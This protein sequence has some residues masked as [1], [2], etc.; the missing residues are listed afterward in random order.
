MVLAYL[1]PVDVL[2][3]RCVQRRWY[4]LSRPAVRFNADYAAHLVACGHLNF[5]RRARDNMCRWDGRAYRRP[6]K[7]AVSI[8]SF[9][10]GTMVARGTRA[11]AMRPP[12]TAI[13]M[14]SGGRTPMDVHG[15][16]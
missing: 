11:H 12:R 7:L 9:G 13:S 1:D 15:T 5:L 8:S 6:P 14:P 3:A 10:F 4:A 16:P 2:P